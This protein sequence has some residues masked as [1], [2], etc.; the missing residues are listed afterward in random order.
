MLHIITYPPDFDA[1]PAKG[2]EGL[3]FISYQ[4]RFANSS[5]DIVAKFVQKVV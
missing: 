2:Q 1:D 4:Y 3:R 5:P